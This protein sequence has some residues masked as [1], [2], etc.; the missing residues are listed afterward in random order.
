M[1]KKAKKSRRSTTS[2]SINAAVRPIRNEASP[3]SSR[4][5][6]C[7]LLNIDSG[8]A[9]QEKSTSDESH[10][11]IPNGDDDYDGDDDEGDAF[12]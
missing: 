11:V 3:S 2:S 12:L 10:S 9:T 1:L 5:H 7:L 8:P 4:V 6:P